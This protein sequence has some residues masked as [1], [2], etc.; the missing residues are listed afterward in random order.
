M[1]Q[2]QRMSSSRLAALVSAALLALGLAGCGA[3]ANTDTA[4]SSTSTGPELDRAFVA[5]MVPH[6][7]SAIAMAE[8]AKQRGESDFVNSLADDIIE[9]QSAE[10]KTLKA[11]DGQLEA[12]GVQPGELGVP[13]HMMGM[14]SDVVSLQS[15][16]PFDEVFIDMMVPHHQGA[17]VMARVELERGEDPRLQE[18]AEAIVD[19]Q[20]REID[21]MNSFREA[22][23]GAPSPAGG[24]PPADDPGMGDH[25][26]M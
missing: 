5:E 22:E 25:Q 11:V 12:D 13:A 8:V 14:D 7:E 21:A 16:D 17:V 18:L 20:S 10:V 1:Q 19:A 26:G 4:A 6:H 23:F 15:A 2:I 24:V 3:G 9:S